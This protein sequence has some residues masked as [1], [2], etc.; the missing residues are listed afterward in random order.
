[1]KSLSTRTQFFGDSVFGKMSHLA[2]KHNAINL[3]QGFPDFDGPQWI[4]DIVKKKID[5]GDNQYA[6][7]PGTPSLRQSISGYMKHFYDLS[8]DP[9]DHISV[10]AGATEAIFAA[11]MAMISPGDEVIIFEP[12]YDS[13]VTSIQMAGGVPIP[14]TLHAPEFDINFEELEA[15]IS[16][17]TKM[18]IFNNPQNPSGKVFSKNTIQQL[19]DTTIKND[20]YLMSD[21]V[22]EF[23][24][25]DGI[26][27]L[28]TATFEN[29][30][31]RTLTISSGGK[32]FGFTG[33]K[34]GWV[35][36]NAE[37]SE[38]IR[39]VHQYITF[40]VSTPMQEGYAEALKLEN[41]STY[42][43][44]YQKS[45]QKMRD[46]F[47]SGLFDAGFHP[48]KSQ[49]TYFMLLPI[50]DLTDKNDIGYAEELVE[51]KKVASIPPSAFY[52]KSDDG[53]KYLRFCF[54]KKVETL[55]EAISRLS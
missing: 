41:F 34:I 19:C 27:H 21:E 24:V 12:F 49:A 11:I 22:Y 18:I 43:P 31:E 9:N 44:E 2:R 52:L 26:K 20:L 30:W 50:S 39:K 4:R 1:M 25:F 5:N 46:T 3:G 47:Y 51:S 45:Y 38:N 40:S 14:V 55:R 23:L 8:Y 13:Y 7:F 36:A 35:C 42:I 15:A 16:D 6:P 53:S 10:T 29:M 17:K 48:I 28:P 54:A 33:W 32:I 37:I